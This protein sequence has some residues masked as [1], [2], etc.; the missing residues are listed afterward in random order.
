LSFGAHLGYFTDS[1]KQKE[2]RTPSGHRSD[3]L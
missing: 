1:L 3:R 2:E